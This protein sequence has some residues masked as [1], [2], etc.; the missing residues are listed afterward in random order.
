[1]SASKRTK[2]GERFWSNSSF[3][4]GQG[5]QPAFSVSRKRQAGLY[6][7]RGKVWEVCKNL[8]LGHPRS[9]VFQDVGHR[10]SCAANV[11][12]TATLTRLNSDDLAI[13]HVPDDSRTIFY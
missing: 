8:L 9:Q 5:S 6:I 4:L 1:M 2:R 12:F 13:I 3:I 7:F 10:H 11:W